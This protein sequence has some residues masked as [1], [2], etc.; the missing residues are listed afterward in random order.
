MKRLE[1][2]RPIN[3]PVD[4]FSFKEVLR[5]IASPHVIMAVIMSVML[6]ATTS[7]LSLFLPSIVRQLGFSPNRT[8]LLSV[9]P[10]VAG[11]IGQGFKVPYIS[12]LT[13]LLVP[14]VTLISAFL[15][16]RYKSRGIP[17]ALVPILAIAG[18]T[19]FLSNALYAWIRSFFLTSLFDWSDA[20]HKLTS[21]GAL[22]LIS[23]G[24]YSSG[25]VLGAWIANNSEPYYRRAT[26]IALCFIASNIVCSPDKYFFPLWPISFMTGRHFEYLELPKQRRT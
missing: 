21:Y 7:G 26:A 8:Q 5:C 18:Y 9:G 15:S 11:F 16:D 20:E 3:K 4:I 1:R 25:P 6:G 10:H 19:L 24:V 13:L 12:K 14:L 22:F 2:D 17:I 23:L